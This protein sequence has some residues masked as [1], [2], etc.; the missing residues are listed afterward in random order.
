LKVNK[1]DSVIPVLLIIIVT[2]LILASIYPIRINREG[3]MEIY[4][5]GHLKA[6]LK[7][8]TGLVIFSS[9]TCPDC[10]KL[11][12]RY[13]E[14]RQL[15]PENIL[16]IEVLFKPGLT[17]RIFDE[18]SIM[19]TPT[20]MVFRDGELVARYDG[21]I[22]D[23][24]T[25]IA[26]WVMH[27]YS[28]NQTSYLQKSLPLNLGVVALVILGFLAA[29]SPCSLPFLFIVGG[30][31]AKEASRTKDSKKLLIPIIL[32]SAGILVSVALLTMFFSVI[33]KLFFKTILFAGL[34]LIFAGVYSVIGQGVSRFSIK[35]E[36]KND[37]SIYFLSGFVAIQC[38][39]PLVL[40]SAGILTTSVLTNKWLV[41]LGMLL[42]M[43]IAFILALIS[44][45]VIAKKTSWLTKNYR[46]VEIATGLIF[47]VAGI[48]LVLR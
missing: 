47:L 48:I 13:S 1:Q 38:N 45:T 10:V 28:S 46:V 22:S 9:E 35:V 33:S 20:F 5:S 23:D 19:I 24:P 4:D 41:A 11:M 39:A 40:G 31:I 6:L 7:D 15:L 36:R 32:F 34:I 42:G 14:L 18:Y 3:V 21:L 30:G 12:Q 44:V 8:N 16:L 29:F 37:Y 25:I 27:N 2:S 43:W 26:Q 17:D